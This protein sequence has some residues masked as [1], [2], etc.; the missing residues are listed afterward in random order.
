MDNMDKNE[1][2]LKVM[3]SMQDDVNKGIVRIDSYFMQQIGVSPGD[4][5]EI[6]GGRATAGIVG[7]GYPGDIGQDIIRTDPLI[8]RNAKTGIGDTVAVQK[9]EVSEAQRVLVAPARKDVRVTASPSL[10]KRGLIGRVVKKG[11]LVALGGATKRRSAMSSSPF[12]DEVFSDVLEEPYMIGL[13]G[14]K[15]MVV[16]VKPVKNFTIITE[17]T[18]VDYKPE[19][20]EV[21]D[22]E[23]SMEIAY[24]DIGGLKEEIKKIR[25][26]VEL[27]LK[28]PEIFERLGIEAPK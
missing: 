8:R 21:E 16:D 15:F 10:F 23:R 17:N 25:E 26:M 28:H 19:A 18:K 11:D 6:K 4:I 7:R 1:V 14:L 22:D 27:P 20:V 24:E 12:F 3:E 2:K 9:A 13:G 5:V